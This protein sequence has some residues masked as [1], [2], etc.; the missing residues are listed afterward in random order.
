MATRICVVAACAV[1]VVVSAI[2]P[3]AAAAYKR[4]AAIVTGRGRGR[5]GGGR[6]NIPSSTSTSRSTSMSTSRRADGREAVLLEPEAAG[7]RVGVGQARAA[8]GREAL[9]SLGVALA[10]EHRARRRRDVVDLEPGT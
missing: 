4:I 2:R 7:L 3:S 1:L 6:R 10:R 8:R 9:G 5:A